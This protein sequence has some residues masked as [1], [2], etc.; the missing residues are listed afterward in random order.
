M[1]KQK[2]IDINRRKLIEKS[3]IRDFKTDERYD[4][5]TSVEVTTSGG[6]RGRTINL[7]SSPLD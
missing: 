2:K 4:F 3:K 1:A 5:S 6:G 7:G